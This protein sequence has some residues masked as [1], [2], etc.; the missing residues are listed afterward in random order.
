VSKVGIL[1]LVM[2]AMAAGQDIRDA[3]SH[4]TGGHPAEG[5]RSVE[6][7]GAALLGTVGVVAAAGALG[8]SIPV[9]GVIAAGVGIGLL[10]DWVAKQI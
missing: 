10:G 7:A 9:L 4:M 8:V 2:P 3:Y 6:R 5:W 1:G